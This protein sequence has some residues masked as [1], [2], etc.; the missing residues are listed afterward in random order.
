MSVLRISQSPRGST[1]ELFKN[2]FALAKVPKNS[3]IDFRFTVLYFQRTTLPKKKFELQG[4]TFFGNGGATHCTYRRKLEIRQRARMETMRTLCATIFRRGRFERT[5]PRARRLQRT[6]ST[7]RG[8]MRLEFKKIFFDFAF[9]FGRAP[10]KQSQALLLRFVAPQSVAWGCRSSFGRRLRANLSRTSR[11]R[12][13]LRKLSYKQ[14]VKHVFNIIRTFFRE[15]W[16]QRRRGEWKPKLMMGDGGERK[17]VIKIL[18]Y[19]K[20]DMP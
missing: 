1:P 4:N 7:N 19:M 15:G 18:R 11:D 10:S 6:P 13:A 14:R 2:G 20:A 3:K 12:F 17:C 16:T 8:P 5:S 9:R